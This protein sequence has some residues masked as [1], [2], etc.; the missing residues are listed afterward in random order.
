MF[1]SRVGTSNIAPLPPKWPLHSTLETGIAKMANRDQWTIWKTHAMEI[2][3]E[4]LH[5]W[6]R[7]QKG[8]I[9]NQ[10]EPLF[11][12]TCLNHTTVPLSDEIIKYPE[13]NTLDGEQAAFVSDS[14]VLDYILLIHEDMKAPPLVLITSAEMLRV[15]QNDRF[16]CDIVTS[17][18]TYED[19]EFL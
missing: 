1:G 15:Q 8:N 18:H 14:D 6:H 16:C 12:L 3:A 7:I 10:T 17:L 4:Q 19:L 5:I 9:N 13:D 11:L 2:T